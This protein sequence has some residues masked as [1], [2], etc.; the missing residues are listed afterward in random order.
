MSTRTIRWRPTLRGGALGPEV[1]AEIPE[2][3]Y[4][5]LADL[6]RKAEALEPCDAKSALVAEIRTLLDLF[7]LFPGT[8]VVDQ[9]V[10]PSFPPPDANLDEALP[11]PER[12]ARG[13]THRDGHPTERAA[14]L[15]A[16]PRT[17]TQRRLILDAI[18]ASGDRGMTHDELALIPDVSDRAHRTRRKELEKDGWVRDSGRTR[19]TITSTDAVV[20]VL[21]DAGRIHYPRIPTMNQEIAA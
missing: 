10:T 13:R 19:E 12:N 9:P 3:E 18:A 7:V 17:G 4:D 6:W 16:Y 11:D 15:A 8:T 2:S 20:W 5:H 14:A 21:T 1:I